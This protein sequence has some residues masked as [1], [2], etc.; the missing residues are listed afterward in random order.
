M[1]KS[2]WTNMYML[3]GHFEPFSSWNYKAIT[4]LVSTW[5]VLSRTNNIFS[6]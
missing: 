5:D 4:D 6:D 1:T 3:Q 2:T